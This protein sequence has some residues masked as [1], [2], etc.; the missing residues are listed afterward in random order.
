MTWLQFTIHISDNIKMESGNMNYFISFLE[1]IITFISPCMLPMLPIYAL[2][3][4]GG[5]NSRRK[6]FKNAI[7]FILG[8]TLVFISLGAFAGTL[9]SLLVKYT[10]WVNI[11][12]GAVIVVFGL[13]YLGLFNLSIFNVNSKQNEKIKNLGFWSSV[14]FGVTFSVGW[15]PCVGAF[16][17]SALMLAASSQESLKGILMLLSF[18]IGLGVPFLISA[19]LLDQ[20]KGLFEFI[21]RNYKIINILSGSM[22]ILLGIVMMTGIMGRLLSI[23]NF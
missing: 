9:G 18:S 6:T 7:G 17:G 20:L 19:L 16:L 10:K 15:T 11:F 12:T 1:G 23:I 22:L 13:S 14:I 3:F 4:A 8:F 5:E 21:K 2:Y